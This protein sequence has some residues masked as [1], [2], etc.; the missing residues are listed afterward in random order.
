MSYRARFFSLL[1]L[2]LSPTLLLAQEKAEYREITMS[3][4][5]VYRGVVTRSDDEKMYVSGI[6]GEISLPLEEVAD[7]A[8][9]SRES[10]LAGEGR[11]VIFVGIAA[12]ADLRAH[13]D[14]LEPVLYRGLVGDPP[15]QSWLT[16]PLSE[17]T[18]ARK[19]AVTRCKDDTTC[20]LQALKEER[21]IVVRGFLERKDGV[22]RLVLRRYD[23]TLEQ[24]NEVALVLDSPDVEQA[25]VMRSA[26]LVLGEQP[27]P[28]KEPPPPPPVKREP[29]AAAFDPLPVPGLKA[30][31]AGKTS[32]A[33]I[34]LGSVTAL[35]FSAVYLTGNGRIL[36]AEHG[37][38]VPWTY[39]ERAGKDAAL[40]VGTGAVS[41]LVTTYLVNQLVLR[42]GSH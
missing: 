11:R 15:F 40:L 31:Q 5:T 2:M 37:L 4:G 8:T 25:R 33:G 10:Y 35:T 22:E 18:P 3:D 14:Q 23:R 9:I 27:P 29:V 34:A 17:V 19:D 30:L 26:A 20:V 41:Y 42:I 12:P 36:G 24:V 13:A 38:P 16:L 6:K 21:S 39:E 1:T 32:Q 28:M 7:I